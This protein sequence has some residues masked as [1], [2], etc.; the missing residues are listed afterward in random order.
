M[1]FFKY[2][3]IKLYKHFFTIKYIYEMNST[4][5]YDITEYEYHNFTNIEFTGVFVRSELCPWN[6]ITNN[7]DRTKQSYLYDYH[8]FIKY[9]EKVYAD[10]FNVGEIVISYDELQKNQYLKHYYDLSHM[11]ADNKNTII[12]RTKYKN[13]EPFL[14]NEDRFWGID[15]AFLDGSYKNDETLDIVYKIANNQELYYYKINPYDLE[16]MEYSLQEKAVSFHSKYMDKKS[17]NFWGILFKETYIIYNN[18][19]KSN[20]NES[21]NITITDSVVEISSNAV[22]TDAAVETSSNSIINN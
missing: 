21:S 5:S 1:I 4:I 16:N 3:N 20:I 19:I 11:I 15:C 9:G 10:F 18:L 2:N 14:Y 13:E 6:N 8:L 17:D 12:K 7:L 22:I